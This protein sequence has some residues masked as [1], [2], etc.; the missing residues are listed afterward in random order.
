MLRADNP[1]LASGSKSF[2]LCFWNFPHEFTF[3]GEQSG[4]HRKRRMVIKS[5]SFP[6][7]AEIF[8]VTL[9]STDDKFVYAFTLILPGWRLGPLRSSKCSACL[10]NRFLPKLTCFFFLILLHHHFLGFWDICFTFPFSFFFFCLARGID[11][12]RDIGI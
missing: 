3:S 7:T 10:K 2:K 5:V 12:I 6:S 8:S 4:N 9:E 1:S 11:G